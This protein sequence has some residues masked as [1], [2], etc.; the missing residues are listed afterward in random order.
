[1]RTPEASVF[2]AKLGGSKMVMNDFGLR[3]GLCLVN[4]SLYPLPFYLKYVVFSLPS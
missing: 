3:F 2:L 1:M 4:Y